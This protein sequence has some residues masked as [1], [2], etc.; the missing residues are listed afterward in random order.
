MDPFYLHHIVTA[1]AEIATALENLDSG[2]PDYDE[3]HG[4][5]VAVTKQIEAIISSEVRR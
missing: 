5:L 4:A 1:N 3:K 2:D